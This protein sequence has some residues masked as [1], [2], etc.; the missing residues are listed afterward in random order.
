MTDG[1]H[2]RRE[3]KGD[4]PRVMVTVEKAGPGFESFMS[5]CENNQRSCSA[6]FP[7][8]RQRLEG[9]HDAYCALFDGLTNTKDW[10]IGIFA[11]RAHSAY[12]AAAR[13]ALS[14]QTVEA[15]VMARAC[16][17]ASVYGVFL[18]HHR[19]H[20]L[21]WRDRDLDDASRRRFHEV[22]KIGPMKAFLSSIDRM[23]GE[24]VSKLYDQAIDFGAHPNPLGVLSTMETQDDGA[25][26]IGIENHY[27]TSKEDLIRPALL[28]VC[29]SG[30]VAFEAFRNVFGHRMALLG[31][32]DRIRALREEL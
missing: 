29:R 13:L 17:E 30:L 19:E 16:L 25:G 7:W 28:T 18:H 22:F 24:R 5:A 6:R 9:I 15:Y 31:L 4:E 11:L 3:R 12:L 21:V 20:I 10:A 14:S 27:L 32:E 2:E 8:Y 26:V 23:T 1:R